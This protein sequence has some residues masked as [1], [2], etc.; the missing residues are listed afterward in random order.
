MEAVSRVLGVDAG[1]RWCGAS[2]IEP[3][4]VIASGTF[5]VNPGKARPED[6]D[7]DPTVAWILA[8]AAW[9]G[10]ERIAVE[11]SKTWA[12][13][14]GMHPAAAMATQ[15][16]WVVCDRIVRE[17][18]RLSPIPVETIHV[19][20]WRS[21]VLPKGEKEEAPANGSERKARADAR[22][23][24]AMSALFS[25]GDAAILSALC[26]PCATAAHQRDAAGAAI[27]VLV[28]PPPK[29]PPAP[30]PPRAP[31]PRA[32]TRNAGWLARRAASLAAVRAAANCTCP[33][34]QHR[35]GCALYARPTEYAKPAPAPRPCGCGARGV[36]RSTCD[37]ETRRAAYAA[38]SS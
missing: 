25:P 30:R 9:S 37:P 13:W 24:A 19:Q 11:H 17:L 8:C 35:K 7:V 3:A 23:A 29:A 27:G 26:P 15:A 12:M 34:Q 38:A 28:A 20:T 6:I 1:S 16:N 36:H 2:A 22:V 4:H 18:R 21:R 5:D 14:P 31:G 32:A 33:P 10:A